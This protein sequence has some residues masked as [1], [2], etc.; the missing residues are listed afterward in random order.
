M[1]TP[2]IPSSDSRHGV[3][4]SGKKKTTSHSLMKSTHPRQSKPVFGSN[5]TVECDRSEV[6]HGTP[7]KISQEIMLAY[8][9]SRTSSGQNEV[10]AGE[11][12]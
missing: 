6:V 1:T 9:S 11:Q 4:A 5:V 7:M 10:Y 2:L 12:N 3:P 8:S